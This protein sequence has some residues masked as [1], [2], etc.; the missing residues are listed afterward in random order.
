LE[1]GDVTNGVL[2]RFLVIE[3]K[4]R[5]KERAP[6]LEASEVPTEIIHGM[7]RIYNRDALAS[8]QLCQSRQTPPFISV[9]IS[10]DA[11]QIRRGLVDEITA[12]GDADSTL[13]P[14][15]ARTAE[16]ALRLATIVAVGRDVDNPLIDAQT[17]TWAREFSVWSSDRLADGAGL[18]IADSD[19]Q[20]AANAVRRAIQE[21]GGRVKRRDLLRKLQHR[22]KSR[23]LEDVIK[24]LAESEHIRIE[25][26]VPTGGGKPTMWYAAG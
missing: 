23:E 6:L 26:V 9:P 12:R 22:Y 1:G 15:L 18:Y 4:V 13:E 7:K 2:N 5:P 3:T 25:K 8:A 10:P 11:E 17:M 21:D 14:F 24:S 16:N 19:T 20:A